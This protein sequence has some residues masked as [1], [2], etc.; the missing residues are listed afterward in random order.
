MAEAP[1]EKIISP[2]FSCGIVT[3]DDLLALWK[4]LK[5]TPGCKV[6]LT[7]AVLVG[8]EDA[9]QRKAFREKAGFPLSP[10]SGARVRPVKVC[11]GDYICPNNRR[12]IL[13]L[14]RFLDARFC[15]MEAA[16]KTTISVS[17]CGRCCAQSKVCDIGVVAGNDGFYV[18]LGGASGAAPRAGV[19]FAS[20]VRPEDMER[21]I[22]GIIE[23]HKAH[24]TA[25]MRLGQVIDKIGIAVFRDKVSSVCGLTVL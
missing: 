21:L 8:I 10:V 12:E 14:S 1:D 6:K 11:A 23:V 5:E 18:Y 15:G 7:G 2:R 24:G 9:G 13:A 19:L 3:A 16:A 22:N 20:G 25:G 4:L 17:G